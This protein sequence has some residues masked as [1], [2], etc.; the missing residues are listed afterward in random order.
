MGL[1]I[2]K[3]RASVLDAALEVRSG[4]DG[5]GTTVTCIFRKDL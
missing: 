4:V 5:A 1:H 2:M 3:Y